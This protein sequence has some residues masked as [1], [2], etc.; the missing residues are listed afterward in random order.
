MEFDW[1]ET[2]ERSL[3]RPPIRQGDGRLKQFI[4]V[5]TEQA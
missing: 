3:A 2:A 5:R 1:D 4:F